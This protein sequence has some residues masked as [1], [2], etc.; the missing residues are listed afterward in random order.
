MDLEGGLRWHHLADQW[1]YD[2]RSREFR[3][4]ARKYLGPD[5]PRNGEELFDEAAL[6]V[7]S[8]EWVTTR[9]RAPLPGLWDIASYWAARD[10][11]FVVW[12]N[13]PHCF[14]CDVF[15]PEPDA[16]SPEDRWNTS[17]WWLQRGH[18]VNWARYGLDQI[19]NIVPLCKVCNLSMPVFDAEQADDAVAWVQAGGASEKVEEL[20]DAYKD[21]LLK[22]LRALGVFIPEQ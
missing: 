22:E 14:G 15:D 18:L 11:W 2:A 3:A 19:Q 8:P 16:V 13:R 1:W 9:V 6:R 12:L 20:I 7:W 4:L 5:A 17:G 21:R 10:D